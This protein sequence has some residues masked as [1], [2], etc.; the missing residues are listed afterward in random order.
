MERAMTQSS[1]PRKNTPMLGYANEVIVRRTKPASGHDDVRRIPV[2]VLV[3]ARLLLLDIAGPLE[4]LR[5]ANR[6]QNSVH[7]E[8]RYIGPR[9]SLQT[10][11]GITLAGIEPLPHELPP[12]S[13]I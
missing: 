13:W 1:V 11:I 2:F 6:V 8:V 10:S 4:V 12:H 9:S 7:F 5:Q 3:P